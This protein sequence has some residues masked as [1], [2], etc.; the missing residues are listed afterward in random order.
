[1]EI[2]IAKIY[3]LSKK[4]GN[5]AFGEIFQALNT[6]T[7]EEVA[8]KLEPVTTKHPQLFF[9]SKLYSYIHQDPSVQ[10]KGIPK[11][12]YS[13]TEG[14]YNVMVMDLLGASLEDLFTQSN[15]KLSLKTVLM[16]ADQ[17]IQRIEYLHSRYFLHR[18]IKPDNFLMGH[19]KKASKVYMVDFGLAKRYIGK[20]LMSAIPRLLKKKA[21]KTR[22]Y[23]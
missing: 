23:M 12:Y 10:D 6:K 22:L 16:L 7:N 17:M 20:F 9:E 3:K 14:E 5:G 19:G 4:L 15:R 2:K 18:D 8:I 11:V 1:M 21:D 13:A